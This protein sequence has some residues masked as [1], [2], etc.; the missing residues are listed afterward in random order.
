[1]E[2]KQNVPEPKVVPTYIHELLMATTAQEQWD[3]Y[4]KYK[5]EHDTKTKKNRIPLKT[6]QLMKITFFQGFGQLLILQRDHLSKLPDTEAGDVL[7]KIL[8]E[9]TEHNQKHLKNGKS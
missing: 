3:W 5:I 6:I 7:R 2:E 1:M 4:V 8:D 9:V